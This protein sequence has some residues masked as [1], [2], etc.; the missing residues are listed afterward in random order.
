MHPGA[1]VFLSGRH[2]GLPL[3]RVFFCCFCRGEPVCSPLLLHCCCLVGQTHRSAP[4]FS[5]YLSYRPHGRYLVM[6]LRDPSL[7]IGMTASRFAFAMLLP[8]CRF[9]G[10]THRSAPTLLV[11]LLLRHCASLVPPLH[12]KRKVCINELKPSLLEF[13]QRVQPRLAESNSAQR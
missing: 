12:D 7:R 3:L 1:M 5:S 2:T 9:V 10:Q 11:L 13:L 8:C 6:V 4:T